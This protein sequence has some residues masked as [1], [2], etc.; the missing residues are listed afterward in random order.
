M[1][2]TFIYELIDPITDETRYIGKSDNPSKRLSGHLKD[3]SHT[4]KVSWIKSLKNNNLYPILNIIDE[5]NESEWQFWERFY[6]SLYRSWNCRLV[7]LAQGGEGGSLRK[8]YKTS[9]ETKRKISLAHKG[10]TFSKEHKEKISKNHKGGVLGAL[11]VEHRQK[12]SVALKGIS[13]KKPAW[14][15]GKKTSEEA[16]RKISIAKKA[17]TIAPRTLFTPIMVG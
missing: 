16:K 17:K 13:K 4:Y 6:I 1:K 7:N 9:A 15:K 2:T 5:V 10:K 11:S 14:N 12:I 8:G 3:K